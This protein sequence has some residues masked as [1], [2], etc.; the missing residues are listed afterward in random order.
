[1]V[2]RIFKISRSV[3]RK[4]LRSLEL[5]K[6]N[7]FTIADYFRKQGAIIGEYN[8][9]EVRDLG[10][11]PFLVKIGSHCTIA[12]NVSFLCHDGAT[13]I[14]T[15]EIPSL[16]KFGTIEVKD[17]CFIG[18]NAFILGNITIGPNSIV[19]ACSVVTKDVPPDTVVAGNP[20]RVIC[21]ISEYKK[22]A[23]RIWE[24]Q[25]PPGYFNGLK[26]GKK[27]SPMYIQ[28]LKNKE[29]HKLKKHLVEHLWS[30]NRTKN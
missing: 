6:Y 10:S 27:Y 1:M 11:E 8:R 24:E 3:F 23:L 16:Q 26:D 21:S 17:N 15:D 9:I 29:Y 14:F 20:A 7:D 12:P 4:I 18:I 28:Q 25:R 22:K 2:S 13:W 5:N 30:T 19:G